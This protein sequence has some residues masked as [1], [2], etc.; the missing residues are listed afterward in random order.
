[1]MGT[2]SNGAPLSRGSPYRRSIIHTPTSQN[3]GGS[4]RIIKHKIKEN[5]T[6]AG[7]AIYYGVR[8]LE[9][10]KRANKIW[11][12]SDIHHL[13]HI[14][15]PLELCSIADLYA[16]LRSLE[17]TSV[18]RN[19]ADDVA[20]N[21][22]SNGIPIPP[23][24]KTNFMELIEVDDPWQQQHTLSSSTS[25]ASSSSPT[26]NY[27]DSPTQQ[28][29]SLPTQPT[30]LTTTADILRAVDSDV[31]SAI[32]T[33]R[34]TKAQRTRPP[35][36]YFKLEQPF[37][38]PP[39]NSMTGPSSPPVDSPI[40]P[41]SPGQP[42]V[43]EDPNVTWK[44]FV[45]GGRQPG[46]RRTRV[47]AWTQPRHSRAYS[48]QSW[49]WISNCFGGPSSPTYTALSTTDDASGEDTP[50]ATRHGEAGVTG[51]ITSF[52]TSCLRKCGLWSSQPHASLNSLATN[53]TLRASESLRLGPESSSECKFVV[54]PHRFY[55]S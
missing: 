8:N 6:L 33:I 38:S 41:A 18:G 40:P 16:R 32:S 48:N 47:G 37:T 46:V 36:T 2:S 27:A 34:A 19:G 13:A 1:M 3:G 44:E 43:F 25:S 5:E 17:T 14:T 53:D 35:I 9:E 7:I 39:D 49:N 54:E 10:L 42:R 4:R 23:H 30:T 29:A 51:T 45:G 12:G 20:T 28:Q 11:H 24:S 15:I 31:A 22:D 26:Q 55:S 52:L 21:G 50:V